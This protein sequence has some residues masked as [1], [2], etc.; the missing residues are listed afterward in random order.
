MKITGPKK[1]TTQTKLRLGPDVVR[2]A[3]KSVTGQRKVLNGAPRVKFTRAPSKKRL[4]VIITHLS[5][6]K[7]HKTIE[8]DIYTHFSPKSRYHAYRN[9]PSLHP[10]LGRRQRWTGLSTERQSQ[11]GWC[12]EAIRYVASLATNRIYRNC[13]C[14]VIGKHQDCP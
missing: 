9:K 5:D 4:L 3:Y 10:R 1:S 13:D 11:D 12:C 7:P 6:W 2:R 14:N 8:I